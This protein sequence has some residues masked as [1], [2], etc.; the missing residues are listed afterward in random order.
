MLGVHSAWAQSPSIHWYVGFAS[1]DRS[2]VLVQIDTRALPSNTDL[3]NVAVYIGYLDA[4][5]DLLGG[6]R[7]EIS[8]ADHPALLAGHVYVRNFPSAYAQA[9]RL[10][11][12]SLRSSYGAGGMLYDLHMAQSKSGAV[13]FGFPSGVAAG[14]PVD[15]SGA[16]AVEHLQAASIRTRALELPGSGV[17][18]ANR[19]IGPFCCT[20]E[21][22]T[23]LDANGQAVG[24]VYVFGFSGGVNLGGRAAVRTANVL[25]SGPRAD[26]VADQA[27]SQVDFSAASWQEGTAVRVQAG[28][29]TY[30]V[31]LTNADIVLVGNER[32]FD[33]ESLHAHVEVQWPD[34]KLT[35]SLRR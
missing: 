34:S 3:R 2:Q 4:T 12:Y 33:L 15:V 23:V 6:S 20:G 28:R 25:V 17:K 13:R 19:R 7:L 10:E 27:T 16:S 26:D 5:D 8:D 21:T 24:Y 14:A 1:K 32:A 11:G 31:T 18:N 9:T 35:R 30:V 29:L 22:A